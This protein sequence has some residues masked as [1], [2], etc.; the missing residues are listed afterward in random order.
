MRIAFVHSYPLYHDGWTAAQWLAMENQNRWIPAVLAEMGHAVEYWIGDLA[1]G[2]HVS[3]MAGFPDYLIRRFET[4]PVDRRTKFH[5]SPAMAAHARRHPA[6]LYVIKGVDGGVGGYLIEKVL[7]PEG[8]PFVLILGGQY[9]HRHVAYAGA[10]LYETDYQRRRLARPRRLLPGPRVAPERLIRLPKS[11]DTDLFRPDASVRK[12]YDVVAVARLDRRQKS[13]DELGR[14]SR[15]CS[16]AVAGDGRDAAALRRRYPRVEW[17]G[18]VPHAELPRVLNQGRVFVHPGARDRRPTRDFFPRVIAEAAA[19]GLPV[20]GFSDLIQADVLPEGCGLRVA[21]A[22]LP[23]AVAALLASPARR[24]EM[25]A[26]ARAWA[27]SSLGRRS[28]RS[29]LEA[30]LALAAVPVEEKRP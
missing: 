19:C 30:A 9:R 27:T 10:V 18:A 21:R 26:R 8:R 25:G 16:V 14:L 22:A 12:A 4:K 24:A 7:Q 15:T 23:E 28:A 17:L 13:F 6:D 2:C 20:V 3:Q 11:V 5:I 1:E 29:A